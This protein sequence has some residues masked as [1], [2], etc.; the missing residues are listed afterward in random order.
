MLPPW[1]D[2]LL[3]PGVHRAEWHEVVNCLGFTPHRQRLLRGLLAALAALKSAGC[4]RAWIDGSFVTEKEHP[5]DFDVC[6]DPFAVDPEVLDPVL[7][8]V[9][10]PRFAQH[11]KYGGDIIPNFEE[12]TTGSLFVDFFQVHKETGEP[13]GIIEVDLVGLST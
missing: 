12:G 6:W 13:K 4:E 5:G 10:P 11:V 1:I 8:D 2:G 9:K 3:P 7:L